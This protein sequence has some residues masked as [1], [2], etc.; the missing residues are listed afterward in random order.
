MLWTKRTAFSVILALSG[1]PLAQA[2]PA[3][4]PLGSLECSLLF[5][6]FDQLQTRW[7]VDDPNLAEIRA[8]TARESVT[9]EAVLQRSFARFNYRSTEFIKMLFGDRAYEQRSH[10]HQKIFEM[11]M[12]QGHSVQDSLM[13]ADRTT[14]S[15]IRDGIFELGL[16]D[17]AK[18]EA[19]MS[20]QDVPI[21]KKESSLLFA[22]PKSQTSTANVYGVGSLMLLQRQ[23]G[24][25]LSSGRIFL[26][27]IDSKKVTVI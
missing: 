14:S 4:K 11:A 20:H 3:N 10:L 7:S 18:R 26:I 5:G 17:Y 13:H 16:D 15:V 1:T 25:P 22:A 21:E 23:F 24:M 19:S 27:E 9:T 2:L 6:G 12:D 8:L